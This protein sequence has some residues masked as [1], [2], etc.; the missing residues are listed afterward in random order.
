MSP[1]SREP[2][3]ESATLPPPPPARP[4]ED[5][6]AAIRALAREHGVELR[7]PPGTLPGEEQDR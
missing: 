5:E 2:P 4:R 7:A 3:A 6:V 1:G